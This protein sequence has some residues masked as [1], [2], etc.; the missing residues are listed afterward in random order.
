[1]Q[2]FKNRID[3]KVIIEDFRC[4]FNGVRPHSSLGQ[5]MP[6]EFKRQLLQSAPKRGASPGPDGP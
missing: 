6:L 2:W 3:A 1:M 4:Q 5:L